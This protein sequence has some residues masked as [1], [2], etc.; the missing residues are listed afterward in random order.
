[1]FF[2][3]PDPALIVGDQTGNNS[4]QASVRMDHSSQC[5]DTY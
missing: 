3:L 2:F 5:G 1:M 4:G